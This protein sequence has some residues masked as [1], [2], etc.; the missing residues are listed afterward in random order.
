MTAL[1]RGFGVGR[2]GVAAMLALVLAAA[3]CGNSGDD[4][5]T[6]AAGDD[7][8]AEV[9][10]TAGEGGTE[11][12]GVTDSTVRV[13]GVIALTGPLG[14]QFRGSEPGFRAYIDYVNE[15]GGV[16]GRT[17]ELVEV[18]NDNTDTARNLEEARALVEQEDVFAI[19]PVST[20]VFGA[21]Q[22][23]ADEGVPTFGWNIQEEWRF[24]DNLIGYPPSWE[25]PEAPPFVP[26]PVQSYIAKQLGATKVGVMAYTAPQSKE[27]GENTIE[28]FEHFGLDVVFED[29]SLPL[30]ATDVT[31]DVQKMQEA[32]VEYL[33]TCIDVNGNVT[34]ARSLQR[35]GLDIPMSWPTGY[36]DET[37]ASFAELME[38]VYFTT[39]F[40]PFQSADQS[41]G[42][43]L[44]LE[45]L[46]QRQPDAEI[47]N[48]TLIGWINAMMLVEGL[49][50]AG[51]DLT[52]DKVVEAIRGMDAFD[53]DGIIPASDYTTP[54]EEREV[55]EGCTAAVVTV[56]DGA[57]T[58]VFQEPFLCLEGVETAEDLDAAIAGEPAGT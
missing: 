7:T 38:N 28:S 53:A 2:L 43:Q 35:A 10:G 8:D 54:P 42:M 48:Q 34:I 20:P 33:V 52:R 57:F 25:R 22:Y 41:E 11:V 36:E 16:H 23:L 27:C 3:A 4:D 47:G 17:I 15:Q 29:T 26:A 46:P 19:A 31:A 5:T 51:P 14:Q 58:P 37:L 44:Y 18:A 45:Q 24:G 13:G 40:L 56:E 50:A 49:E 1:R 9:D 55:L 32:G 30:G 6:S 12:P 39:G 21:A